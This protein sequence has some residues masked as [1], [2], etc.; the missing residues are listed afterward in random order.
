[1]IRNL[2]VYYVIFDEIMVIWESLQNND[3]ESY[4]VIALDFQLLLMVVMYIIVCIYSDRLCKFF[5]WN[6]S[7]FGLEILFGEIED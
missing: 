5:Y 1:M 2:N 3:V 4:K 7:R 6:F